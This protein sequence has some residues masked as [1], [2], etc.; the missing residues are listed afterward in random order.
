[1]PITNSQEKFM[2]ELADIY[3]AEHQFLDALKKMQRQATDGKLK[4]MLEEHA[5]QTQEQI[6][7]LE[8]VFS[9]VGASPER[10]PCSGAR[11]LIEEATKVMQEAQTPQIRDAVIIGAATK[12]E[13]YEMVSYKDLVDGATMLKKRGAAR[14]LSENRDEEVKT[15]RK[16]E[17]AATRIEK[18]AA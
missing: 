1:M 12:A 16:L 7:R 9:E 5:V 3:D 15:A 17:R 10:Q 13:H 6:G 18:A 11:G 4:A 2:H 14:L 8:E